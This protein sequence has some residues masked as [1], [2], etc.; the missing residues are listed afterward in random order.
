MLPLGISVTP[1]V[2]ATYR[3]GNDVAALERSN[4]T[5]LIE[6]GCQ[7]YSLACQNP[8]QIFGFSD[9]LSELSRFSVIVIK[10]QQESSLARGPGNID[11]RL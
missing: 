4:G 3:F 10:C 11:Q 5:A 2:N 6:S 8:D 7:N 9:D 1:S